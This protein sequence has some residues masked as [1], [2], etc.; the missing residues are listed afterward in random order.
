MAGAALGIVL[1]FSQMGLA[2]GALAADVTPPEKAFAQPVGSDYFL[3]D[4][5][6]YEAYLKR[7]AGQ[8]DRMKLV[9]IGKTEEGRTMW[10]AIVSSPA[11]LAK[12]DRWFFYDDRE[13]K[14]R[15][16]LRATY[17]ASTFDRVPV[18]SVDSLRIWPRKRV[19]FI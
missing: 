18:V 11:N 15:G 1:A 5:T 19:P 6:A 14:L 12:L 2:S 8:S 7:L 16:L 10:V 9:D 17:R 3:A 13:A 4:Y